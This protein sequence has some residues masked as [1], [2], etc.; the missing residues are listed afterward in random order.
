MN[1]LSTYVIQL[2]GQV[3]EGEV[4]AMSPFHMRVIQN[5]AAATLFS[6]CTDQSGLV[7]LLRHLHRLGFVLVSVRREDADEL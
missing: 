6:V 2:G 4:N 3:E 1:E 5:Q 7:G